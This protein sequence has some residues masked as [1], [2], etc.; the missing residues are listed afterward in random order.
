MADP[1][2]LDPATEGLLYR[3]AQEGVR[4]IARHAGATAAALTVT[5]EGDVVTL[6]VRDD[7][8]GIGPARDEARRHGSVGLELLGQLV[9]AHG[10][11]LDVADG[12]GGGVEMVVVLP[13]AAAP[14]PARDEDPV[15]SAPAPG[16]RR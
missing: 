16:G 12:D 13:A 14:G 7:G 15:G 2:P 8:R 5:R 10:G 11:R 6:T 9:Q 1:G 4:N 3:A